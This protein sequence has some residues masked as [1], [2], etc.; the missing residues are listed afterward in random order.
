[1]RVVS[2]KADEELLELIE[3]LSV[4]MG[5]SR[6]AVIRIA[7]LNLAGKY[8]RPPFYSKRIRVW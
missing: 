5:V 6:S 4:K 3:E 8:R 2:F 1:M 7:I